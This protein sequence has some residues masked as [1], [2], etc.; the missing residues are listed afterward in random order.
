MRWDIFCKVIDNHGDI[1]VCW[2]LASDLANRG[3]HVRLWSDDLSALGWMAPDGH[4][5]IAALP[6]PDDH[7]AT[8]R[9]MTP[10]D[11]V[12]EAFGC[13]I[14]DPVAGAMAECAIAGTQPV[15]INLEYLT[16]EAHSEQNH[17]LP[18]PVLSGSGKGLTKHFFYPGFT[19]ATGGLLREPTLVD[20]QRQ[21]DRTAWLAQQQI[22]WG[23]ERLVS[24]FCYEPAGLSAW[25][26]DLMADSLRTRLLVAFGRAQS[27][28]IDHFSKRIW[29]QP[30]FSLTSSLSISYLPPL[31][32]PDF[33]RLL[34]A[35][36]MNFVRG[37][38]SLVRGIWAGK[39][40]I[41]NI[42][43][44]DDGAHHAKLEAYLDAMAA[45]ESQRRFHRVWN[46]IEPGPLPH[47]DAI[48]WADVATA[49]RHHASQ[50]ADL[51]S[52]L[53]GFAA[54]NR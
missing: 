7:P 48:E 52:Q 8:W 41:W 16:A 18:S 51:T 42:Y 50:L 36:D 31:T 5:N 26:N 47:V 37:E 20:E 11:V 6:W 34:W 33:D 28:V 10:G 46:G 53:L 15:W 45:P 17:R 1:G 4:P 12:V 32:Q 40:L 13:D 44:Q 19:A 14:P 30:S 23:G 3:E 43:P 38:D 39:P 9:R 2:R 29:R 24:L 21:F 22:P 54:E 25:L 35:C 27:A 49:W